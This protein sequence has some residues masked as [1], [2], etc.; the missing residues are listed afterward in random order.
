MNFKTL[1]CSIIVSVIFVIIF[2]CKKSSN[3]NQVLQRVD[4]VKYEAILTNGNNDWCVNL[5]APGTAKSISGG[6]LGIPPNNQGI[7]YF[8][9]CNETVNQE[10]QFTVDKYV[11]KSISLS[12][13]A[14][15]QYPNSTVY[16]DSA[17]TLNI[18]IN[19]IIVAT[20]TN[21]EKDTVGYIIQ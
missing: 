12:I 17:L 2:S 7:Y 11:G 16:Y 19:N 21:K 10:Y 1:S 5:F 6:Y 18:Y 8:G 15:N 14:Y 9:E 13:S 4:T 3:S 20:Q